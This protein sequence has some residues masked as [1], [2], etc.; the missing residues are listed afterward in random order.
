ME[1]MN[2]ILSEKKWHFYVGSIT[3]RK[4]SDIW[5]LKLSLELYEI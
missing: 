4:D 3:Q 2:L 1:K 5:I